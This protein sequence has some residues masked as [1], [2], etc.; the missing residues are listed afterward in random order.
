MIEIHKLKEATTELL[1]AGDTTASATLPTYGKPFSTAEGLLLV[2]K[3][4]DPE[5]TWPHDLPILYVDW[6]TEIDSLGSQDEFIK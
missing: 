2:R 5:D 3:G 4:T 1:V 6:H